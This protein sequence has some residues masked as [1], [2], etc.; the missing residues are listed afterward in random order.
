VLLPLL[1]TAVATATATTATATAELLFL[2][3]ATLITFTAASEACAGEL[4]IAF[5]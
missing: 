1:F 2:L 3:L 4:T 5:N